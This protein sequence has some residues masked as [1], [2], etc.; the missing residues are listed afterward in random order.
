ME[1]NMT[2][3]IQKKLKSIEKELAEERWPDNKERLWLSL[4][5]LLIGLVIIYLYSFI[6]NSTEFYPL[7][8]FVMACSLAGNAT[9]RYS[10]HKKNS[11]LFLNALEVINYYRDKES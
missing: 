6:T 1:V 7:V 11:K 5:G 8:I 10:E 3:E 2:E 9:T 4:S